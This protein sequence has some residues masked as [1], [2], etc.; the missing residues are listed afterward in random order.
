LKPYVSAGAYLDVTYYRG[1]IDN[2]SCRVD[3]R[4]Y[5]AKRNDHI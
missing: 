3:L 2:E 1:I 5:A 4:I